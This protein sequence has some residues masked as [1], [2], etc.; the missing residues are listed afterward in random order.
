[1]KTTGLGSWNRSGTT[2]YTLAALC[3]AA[4]ALSG[5]GGEMDDATQAIGQASGGGSAAFAT[6]GLSTSAVTAGDSLLVSV[7]LSNQAQSSSG[8]VIVY[9][10]FPG[11]TLAGPRFIRVP[12]GQQSAAAVY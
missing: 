1:M 3:A 8:G 10:G 11:A 4:M 5:C 12:N 7:T 9:I 6:L 2:R